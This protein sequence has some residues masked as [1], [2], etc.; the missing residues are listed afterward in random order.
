MFQPGATLTFN[1]AQSALTAGLQAIAAGQTEIDFAGVT[2]VDSA[3]VA[4]ML[5]W[6]RAA[7]SR[8][9]PLV[10]SNLPANLRNLL[11][12]YDVAA[13]IGT[14]SPRIDLPHH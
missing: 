8:A 3:A 2:T 5:A 7:L 6:R 14:D 11:S 1:N 9:E 4:T 12:L 13:L 10:F